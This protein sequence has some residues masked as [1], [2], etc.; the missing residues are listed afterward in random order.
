MLIGI[1]R[2]FFGIRILET[3]ESL[4]FKWADSKAVLTDS[5]VALTIS[6]MFKRSFMGLLAPYDWSG[7]QRLKL[8]SSELAES[9]ELLQDC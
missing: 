8:D 6:P 3:L 4:E 1:L 2:F 7:L 9:P 5:S